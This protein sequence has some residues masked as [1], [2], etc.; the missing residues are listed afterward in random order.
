MSM[1]RPEIVQRF[2]AKR[3][4]RD[5]ALRLRSINDFPRFA[6]ACIRRQFF[7][8]FGFEP[9]AAPNSF[10]EDWFEGEGRCHGGW[11]IVDCSLGNA[12]ETDVRSQRSDG[13]G[14]RDSRSSC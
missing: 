10:H 3:P 9:A 14:R 6:D 4:V 1:L 5:N 7:P 2:A 11:Q 12:K 13:G 8:E